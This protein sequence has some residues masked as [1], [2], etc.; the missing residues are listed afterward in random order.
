MYQ[1]LLVGTPSQD[2][3]L[4]LH[5]VNTFTASRNH[6]VPCSG[7]PDVEFLYSAATFKLRQ[8]ASSKSDYEF[9]VHPDETPHAE[10]HV[11]PSTLELPD[12]EETETL[13]T[14]LENGCRTVSPDRTKGWVAAVRNHSEVMVAFQ[15]LMSGDD[16]RFANVLK[17]WFTRAPG[18]Y[19][20]S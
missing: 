19:W 1:C 4:Q 15:P 3:G 7:C 14:F 16:P 9:V 2:Y 8:S 10:P 18:W 13:E 6:W 20:P 17:C 11:R 5:S 12:M